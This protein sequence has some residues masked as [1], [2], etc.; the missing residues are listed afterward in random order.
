MNLTDLIKTKRT[1]Y[2]SSLVLDVLFATSDLA[3]FTPSGALADVASELPTALS[4][5][6]HRVTIIMPLYAETDP[7]TAKLSKRLSTMKVPLDAKKKVNVTIWEKN[8]NLTVRV[9][10]VDYGPLLSKRPADGSKESAETYAFFSRAVVEYIKMTSV[11][12][13]IVHCNDWQTGLIPTYLDEAKIKIPS[14]LSIYSVENGKF[15]PAK[16]KKSM[17][18]KKKGAS[19]LASGIS[20]ASHITTISSGMKDVLLE[21]KTGVEKEL[22]AKK[23]KF[24]GV[25]NGVNYSAWDPAKDTHLVHQFDLETLNGKRLNKVALQHQFGLPIRPTQPLIAFVGELNPESGIETFIKAARSVL[26]ERNDP[27]DN[28]QVVFLAEGDAK[29]ENAIKKL[30]K[31]F[32]NRVFGHFG[33]EEELVHKFMASAD[34]L[35]IPSDFEP[36]GTQQMYALKYGTLPLVHNVGGLAD[37]VSDADENEDGN[38]FV[39]NKQ[40]PKSIKETINRAIDRYRIPRQWRPVVMNAMNADFSWDTAAGQ[41]EKIYFSTTSK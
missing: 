12:F 19:F 27:R 24:S 13:D 1:S 39:Y 17:M 11:P 31:D 6:G 28:L 5:R 36:G 23:K 16:L 41:Y 34:I 33:L 26:K 30:V 29:F 18:P 7:K 4:S 22:K 15:A 38:G 21:K 3:P 8:I 14:V 10:F 25:L 35:A 2:D 20:S 37:T 40:N 9:V 32:P